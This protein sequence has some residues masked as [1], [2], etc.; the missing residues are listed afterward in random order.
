MTADAGTASG[1]AASGAAASGAAASGAAGTGAS[2]PSV[3][4]EVV[5][6]VT[7]EVVESI[8]RLIPQLSS[9]ALPPNRD[10]LAGIVA[11]PGATLFVGRLDAPGRPIVGTLTLITCR[12][13]TGVHAMIEDVVVDEAAR[14]AGCGAALVAAALERAREAGVRNV[15]LSSR[16]S[17]EAANR[18]Y[19]RMGFEQR[20]TNL[21]RYRHT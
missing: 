20:E 17:R 12:I 7:A 5:T 9:T 19:V 16:P 2:P 11:S 21:Y 4:I 13:P 15:D 8:A 10:E 18:L 1:A 6:E 14:G 3:T